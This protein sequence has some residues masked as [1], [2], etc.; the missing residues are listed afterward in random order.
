MVI[1]YEKLKRCHN[2]SNKGSIDPGDLLY[3]G[4]QPLILNMHKEEVHTNNSEMSQTFRL[5]GPLTSAY[6]S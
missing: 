3:D 5:N 6:D 1:C 2:I 4:G